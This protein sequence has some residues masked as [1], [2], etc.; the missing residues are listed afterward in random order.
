MKKILS[1]VACLCLTVYLT[2]CTSHNDAANP[3]Q[4]VAD[5]GLENPNPDA[6]PADAAASADK[7]APGNTDEQK[8]FLD[9]PLPEDTLGQANNTAATDNTAAQPAAPADGA[10][11]TTPPPTDGTVA[12]ADTTKATPPPT[13]VTPPPA[14]DTPIADANVATPGSGDQNAIAGSTDTSAPTTTET[15]ATEA[16]KHTP[17]PLQKVKEVPFHEGDQLLNAVY[18]SRPADTYQKISSMI[19]GNED[20]VKNLKAAN[21]GVKNIKPGQ[22][23]YYN[24]PKRAMDESK[25]MNY[26]EEAGLPAETYIAKKGDDLKKVS[27]ELLGY[28]AAWKEVWATNNI[29][30]KGKLDEGTEIKFW[31]GAA[32]VAAASPGADGAA[33]NM[34]PPPAPEMAKNEMPPPPAPEMAKNEMPPPQPQQMAQ[35]ELPPPPPPQPQA[36]L[37]PPPPPPP[38]PVPE[39]AK[40]TVKATNPNA[41][42]GMMDQDTMMEVGAAAIILVAFA[43][44][45][46]MRK[47]R[48][49]RA[50]AENYEK[51]GA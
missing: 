4:P 31:R 37:P 44:L 15:A 24:S 18:L 26:Y 2:G 43:G 13:D 11:A 38:A 35:Q 12:A 5:V 41:D 23:I 49:Q 30:S 51:M 42:D 8:A 16:P 33:M 50:A 45:M 9:Q 28:P 22:K 34:P 39:M 48:A 17:M 25:M 46:I 21:P 19:Y 10:A 14:A 40:K 6:L 47:K 20:Q 29:E 27:K 36:E 3:D 7:N 1:L 32:T